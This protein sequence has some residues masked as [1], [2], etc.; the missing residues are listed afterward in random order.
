[1][2]RHIHR[3]ISLFLILATL[4]FGLQVPG[5]QAGMFP[6]QALS[7]Q[8]ADDAA[9]SE[10]LTL[11][12]NAEVQAELVALGVDPVDAAAR[13][14]ALSPEELRLMHDQLEQMPAGAG[15]VGVAVV[16][17]LV[18]VFLDIFGVTDIFTFIN[19]VK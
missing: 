2:S 10:L 11:M 3:P 16:V 17:L 12:A 1:M 19:P 15:I 8:H 9:R 6:T 4:A 14:E 13:V 7:Q 18:L 5:A